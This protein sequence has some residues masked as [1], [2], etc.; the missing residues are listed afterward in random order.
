MRR[1]I[2]WIFPFFAQTGGGQL[3]D[4][5]QEGEVLNEEGQFPYSE[6]LL[7][8]QVIVGND[9]KCPSFDSLPHVAWVQ[10][11]WKTAT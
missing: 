4:G 9:I 5:G 2:P 1:K 10:L 6:P 8:F 7:W 11:C 3:R